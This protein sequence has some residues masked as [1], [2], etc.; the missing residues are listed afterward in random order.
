MGEKIPSLGLAHWRLQSNKTWASFTGVFQYSSLF[1]RTLVKRIHINDSIREVDSDS[2]LIAGKL[3]LSRQPSPS[4]EKPS[5]SDGEGRFFVLSDAPDPLPESKP[6]AEDSAELPMVHA[7]G[8]QSA[9]WRAGEAFIK[10]HDI[11]WP[12]ATREHVTLAF[13]KAKGPL[14]FDFPEVI[15]HD[16][17]DERYYLILTRVPG[18]TLSEEWP[19]M[20]EAM[21]QR[22][23]RRVADICAKLA[24]WK[25]N[26]ICGVDGQQL[27]E[28]YLSEGD[29][30]DMLDP[31]Q[32]RKNCLQMSMDV[33]SL[34]FCHLDLG[35]GNV[36][37]DPAK[38]SIGIIDWELAGY[39]PREWVKTKFTSRSGL[40]VASSLRALIEPSCPAS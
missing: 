5:W 29:S 37:V 31:D 35:P 8:D 40:L 16:E 18:R 27:L 15:Y 32:L 11:L 26:A 38:D 22:Y 4:S 13:L 7:A 21:R 33:S 39:V 10:A 34:V 24:E 17:F 28:V 6:L 36:I 9:V 14:D 1:A 20:D 2:W 3:L 30:A 23:V 12:N 19:G 25:G